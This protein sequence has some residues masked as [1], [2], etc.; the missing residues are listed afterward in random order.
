MCLDVCNVCVYK[1]CRML[2]FQFV[3]NPNYIHIL[4]NQVCM[5]ECHC[6]SI[7]VYNSLLLTLCWKTRNNMTYK[8][9]LT[10]NLLRHYSPSSV[11]CAY[12]YFNFTWVIYYTRN[13]I[14][15]FRDRNLSAF[16]ISINNFAG[17]AKMCRF[18]L[19]FINDL[20]FWGSMKPEISNYVAQTRVG[21]CCRLT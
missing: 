21:Y 13:P 18:T 19:L 10:A 11:L 9:V 15:V 6:F 3:F 1:L 7:Y 8:F 2:L 16:S 4:F 14:H 12:N 17:S 20:L 5:Y